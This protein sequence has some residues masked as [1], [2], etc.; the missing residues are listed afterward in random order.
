MIGYE[1]EKNYRDYY[2][3]LGIYARRNI[4]CY[5]VENRI[6]YC[7]SVANVLDISGLFIIIRSLHRVHYIQQSFHQNIQKQT[8]L[9]SKVSISCFA[10]CRFA[11]HVSQSRRISM[12]CT[13]FSDLHLPQ[14]GRKEKM[15]ICPKTTSANKLIA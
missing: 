13:S 2:I 8:N 3:Y 14:I 1:T 12:T 9:D 15:C 10:I 11:S 4:H 5:S 7:E 6:W